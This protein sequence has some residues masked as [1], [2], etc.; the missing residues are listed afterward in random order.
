MFLLC[1]WWQGRQSPA[2][3]RRRQRDQCR[4][5]GGGQVP[6]A[7]AVDCHPQ[8]APVTLSLPHLRCMLPLPGMGMPS[9][10]Q[11]IAPVMQFQRTCV[12]VLPLSRVS[13]SASSSA[14]SCSGAADGGK[15]AAGWAGAKMRCTRN[16]CGGPWPES[17]GVNLPWCS[18]HAP[19]RHR[20]HTACSGLGEHQTCLHQVGKALQDAAPLVA[21]HAGPGPVVV[22]CGQ[23][24]KAGVNR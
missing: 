9:W 17:V 18:G 7:A 14:C 24:R 15:G 10:D 16:A 4:L 3:G 23:P 22:G 2:P 11:I 1:R 5:P 20:L 6:W 19:P 12:Y 13:S 8:P 21:S